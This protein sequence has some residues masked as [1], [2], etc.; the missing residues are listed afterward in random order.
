MSHAATDWT[1]LF[2]YP[3]DD[4]R[5]NLLGD[6]VGN[7]TVAG[8]AGRLLLALRQQAREDE[9]HGVVVLV[10]FERDARAVQGFRSYGRA[11]SASH[12]RRC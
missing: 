5:L 12:G 4:Q 6:R 9:S 11:L 1:G 2:D 7:P 10:R 8:T 3:I